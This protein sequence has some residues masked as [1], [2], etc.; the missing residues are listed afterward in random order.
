MDCTELFETCDYAPAHLVQSILQVLPSAG[1]LGVTLPDVE[2]FMEA[3]VAG[4]SAIE[5][6]D[7]RKAMSA[8]LMNLT[9]HDDHDAS[10]DMFSRILTPLCQELNRKKG[11][12]AK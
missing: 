3:D 7:A 1:G 9:D 12:Q 5:V 2:G 10:K 11:N 8:A 4:R 6:N